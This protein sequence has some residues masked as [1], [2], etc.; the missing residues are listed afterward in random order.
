ML[1]T[2]AQGSEFFRNQLTRIAFEESPT[3][4]EPG[5]AWADGRRSVWRDI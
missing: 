1:F 5:F 4:T 2:Q 3:A